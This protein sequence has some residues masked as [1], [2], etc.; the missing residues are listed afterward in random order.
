MKHIAVALLV[1]SIVC[2]C[3]TR[4][5]RTEYAG[6][7]DLYVGWLDLRAD[8]Y[9][10]YGYPTKAEWES[11]ISDINSGLQEYIARYL[12]HYNVTGAASIRDRQPAKGYVILF[13]NPSIDPQSSIAVD[14]TIKNAATGKVIERFPC[15]GTSFHMSYSMYSFAGRLNNAC[16]ALAYEIYQKMTE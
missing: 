6:S 9:R 12:K 11:D 4:T 3:S 2:S 10:K 1:C 16:Y 8:D 7:T 14:I 5:V 15:Y 13:S